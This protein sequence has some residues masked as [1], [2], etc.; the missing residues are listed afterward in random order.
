MNPEK[1]DLY[2]APLDGEW[3]KSS[4][5]TTNGDV[6]VRLMKIRGGIALGDSKAPEREPLRY[7]SVELRAFLR[8]A[9]AGEFDDLLV[10]PAD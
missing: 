2:A 5:S 7:T 3:V 8:G 10:D 6:C 9:K 1:H 4:Y